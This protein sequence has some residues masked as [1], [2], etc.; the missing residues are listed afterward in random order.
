[1]T[2]DLASVNYVDAGRGG[3]GRRALKTISESILAAV[4]IMGIEAT[5]EDPFLAEIISA[6]QPFKKSDAAI[7]AETDIARDLKLDSLAVM[8]LLMV[9]EDKFDVS[10][11]LNMVAEITTVGQLAKAVRDEKAGA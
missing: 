11:P 10:I 5:N 7:T 8:D 1:V 6:L 2:R 9:L 4:A 3:L